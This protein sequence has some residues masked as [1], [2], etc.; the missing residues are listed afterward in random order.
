MT[1]ASRW[2]AWCLLSAEVAGARGAH[3]RHGRRRAPSSSTKPSS[4]PPTSSWASW[5]ATTCPRRSAKAASR[6]RRRS[7]VPGRCHWSSASGPCSAPCSSSASPPTPKGTAPTRPSRPSTTTREA[8]ASG[9]S[10]SRSSPRPSPSARADR[11]AGRDRPARSAP[12]SPP[13]LA[14]ELDLSPADARM[15]VATGIGSGIGA[16]FGAPLGGAVLATEILYRDDFDVEALLPCFVAS[17][18]G[19]VI[20]GAADRLHAAVRLQ[21]QLPLQSIPSHLLWFALIGVLGGLIGLLYAKGFYG[22]AGSLQP[23]SVCPAG[24]S[25]PS[26]GLLVGSHRPGHPRGPRH[27]VRLD[28]AEP[29]P[30]APVICPSGSSSSCPSP[31]SWPPGCPSARADR[32]ASSDRAWSS[33]PSSGPRSGDCSTRSSPPWATARRPTSSWA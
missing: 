26:A 18:V 23:A 29:R 17:I 10:S 12:A 7:P 3:R 9:R 28:P 16:I 15:A 8:S 1:R 6:R 13:C 4:A 33:A 32:A 24:S 27:R 11:A 21:R 25:R 20:F 30:P 31:A 14:R 19:Y 22:I 5:P 2:L